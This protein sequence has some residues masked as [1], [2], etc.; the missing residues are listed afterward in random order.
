MVCNFIEVCSVSNHAA[1][2]NRVQ[3]YYFQKTNILHKPHLIFA[4]IQQ[5]GKVLYFH[6][7]DILP[8]ANL[9]QHLQ[10]VPFGKYVPN[11]HIAHIYQMLGFQI[12][13]LFFAYITFI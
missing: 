2:C 7:V 1:N 13:W 4:D 9:V 3:L 11:N 12:E 6:L 10:F 8:F 5:S